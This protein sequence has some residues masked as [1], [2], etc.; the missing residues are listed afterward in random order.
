MRTLVASRPNTM[1]GRLFYGWVIVAASWLVLFIAYGLQFSY[2]VFVKAIETELGWS[3]AETAL[4]YSIYVLVYS[5]LSSA[6]GLATDRLGPRRVVA[7]SSIVL[8]VGW[9][10]SSRVQ[11]PWQLGV[12][13]GVVAAVGMSGTWAPCNGTVVRW[14]TRLRG[15]AVAV[16]TTGGSFG[17]LVVPAIAAA[18]VATRGWRWTLASLAII[19]GLSILAVS[20]LFIRDPETIGA[21]PDGD[22]SPPPPAEDPTAVDVRW[23][24]PFLLVVGAYGLT[25]LAVFIPFIHGAAFAEDLG[26]SPVRAATV[27]SAM[28]LGGIIGRLLTGSISDRLGRYPTLLT[29]FGLE[30]GAFVVFAFAT[31]LTWLWPAA[32]LFGFSYGGG[33]ALFP[34]LCGDIWGRTHA[35]AIVGAAFARAGSTAA[36]GPWLAGWLYD[37]SGD[38][39]SSFLFGAVVNLLGFGMVAALAFDQRA[40]RPST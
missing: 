16:S 12:T 1:N 37:A 38:Y 17:N 4:P 19:A 11:E 15:T 3:R 7:L 33:V 28:G 34:P 6:T 22:T 18:V 30:T 35:G 5:A 36:V 27:I 24:R 23:S 40:A 10:L 13:L 9:G 8:A 21:Y 31:G 2:G 29:M 20:R 26:V 25:W 39:Q 14:F 32:A